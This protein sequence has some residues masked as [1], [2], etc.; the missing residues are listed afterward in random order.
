MLKKQLVE[1]GENRYMFNFRKTLNAITEKQVVN[2][3]IYIHDT[4]IVLPFYRVV[5]LPWAGELH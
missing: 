5:K 1:H 4:R 2:H 3:C